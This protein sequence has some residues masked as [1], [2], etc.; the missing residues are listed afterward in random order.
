MEDLLMEERATSFVRTEI[1]DSVGTSAAWGGDMLAL[2]D[3]CLRMTATAVGKFQEGR[4]I[5]GHI[6][7]GLSERLMFPRPA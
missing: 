2:R 1:A 7:C 3:H 5:L 6:V 4:I